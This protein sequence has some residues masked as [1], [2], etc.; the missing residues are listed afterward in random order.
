MNETLTGLSLLSAMITPAVLISACGTLVFSTSTRLA[1]VVDRVRHLSAE[2]AELAKAHESELTQERVR[3]MEVQL[4]L[5]ARRSR[6]VQG[7]LTAYYVSLGLFVAATVAI[8][9]T[10]F[11]SHV[12]W[13]PSTLGVLGTLVLFAGSVLLISETRLAVASLEHE[14]E[15][16]IRLFDRT[17]GRR[18]GGGPPPAGG[19]GDRTRAGLYATA[20]GTAV[21]GAFIWVGFALLG[22]VGEGWDNP[23]FY[24]IGVPLL[25]LVSLV[26]GFLRPRGAVVWGLTTLGLVPLALLVAN[27]RERVPLT[28]TGVMVLAGLAASLTIF[29]LL[30]AGAR[31]AMRPD[32]S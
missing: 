26:A 18:A 11:V 19:A 4:G 24:Q 14:M 23:R 17:L 28:A 16:T 12:A 31:W 2:A 27:A 20:S 8:G 30:G 25:G 29:S 13:V 9:L 1:R 21:A 15:T 10:A 5:Y 22:D 7:A 3:Q 32:R 6:L